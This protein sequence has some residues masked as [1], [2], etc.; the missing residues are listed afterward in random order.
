MKRIFFAM[1]PIFY[2]I[3]L[4]AS[5]FYTPS[6]P[7]TKEEEQELLSIIQ[8]FNNE[9]TPRKTLK[10]TTLGTPS[11]PPIIKLIQSNTIKKKKSLV[12]PKTYY[13]KKISKHDNPF[14]I[15]KKYRVFR[16]NP[17]NPYKYEID[18]ASNNS[19]REKIAFIIAKTKGYK[20]ALN[21]WKYIA[22]KY[23][24]PFAMKQV[25][26]LYKGYFTGVEMDLEKSAKWFKLAS[27]TRLLKEKK[28][29]PE[30][31]AKK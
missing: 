22:V 23:Q 21:A 15:K 28:E 9:D 26:L 13:N 1:I 2:S 19:E 11:P 5:G 18:R 8:D 27:E 3:S 10:I 30:L 4:Q 6:G 31:Y 14:V 29:H 20:E 7:L 12:K 17:N 24:D 16:Y 25:G